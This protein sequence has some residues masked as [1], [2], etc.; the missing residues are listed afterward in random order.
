MSGDLDNASLANADLKSD[1]PCLAQHLLRRL[2]EPDGRLEFVA[3]IVTRP[4]VIDAAAGVEPGCLGHQQHGAATRAVGSSEIL[5]GSAAGQERDTAGWH[6][7]RRSSSTPSP[8]P[9]LVW[10]WCVA[11]ERRG[12]ETLVAESTLFTTQTRFIAPRRRSRALQRVVIG[13]Q[14]VR[15]DIRQSSSLPVA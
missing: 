14:L 4:G 7:H 15:P 1:F 6:S 13:A 5:G 9:Q 12:R 10:T 11:S 2:T 3:A 8:H